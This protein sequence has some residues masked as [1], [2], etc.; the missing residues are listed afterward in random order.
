[1]L[2]SLNWAF[3]YVLPGGNKLRQCLFKWAL[4]LKNHVMLEGKVRIECLD[5]KFKSKLKVGKKCKLENKVEIDITGDVVIGDN[6]YIGEEVLIRTHK[7]TL[8][9]NKQYEFVR[10]GVNIGD[11]VEINARA[12]IMEGCNEI[13]RYATV[14]AGAVLLEDVPPYAIVVGNPAKIVGFKFTPEE[15]ESFE[16]DLYDEKDKT[17]INE[18][19][20]CYNKRFIDNIN[21]IARF[22]NL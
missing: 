11:G 7:L 12:Y 13:G 4:G 20:N 8:S 3:W 19:V 22:V 15:I 2:K 14:G 6:C 18:F 5:G 9:N 21:E 1:M 16:K 17:P 10:Q